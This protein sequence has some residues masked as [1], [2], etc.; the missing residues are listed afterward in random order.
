MKSFVA[1]DEV[2]GIHSDIQIETR[3]LT[4][5]EIN[6][7]F[8]TVLQKYGKQNRGGLRKVRRNLD[9]MAKLMVEEGF[10]LSASTE[11]GIDLV[12]KLKGIF[13]P[14]P[15]SNIE[16]RE[17]RPLLDRICGRE[18]TYEIFEYIVEL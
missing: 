11:E 16:F 17:R 8:E 6:S 13:I 7:F 9:G 15:G 18:P 2:C 4:Y 3:T 1:Y 10:T 5:Q 12:T 14:R